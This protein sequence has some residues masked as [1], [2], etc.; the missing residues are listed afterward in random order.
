MVFI[1]HEKCSKRSLFLYSMHLLLK[2]VDIYPWIYNREVSVI[3][4]SFSLNAS[5]IFG[6]QWIF[7]LIFKWLFNI[8]LYSEW[9]HILLRSW[10]IIYTMEYLFYVLSMLTSIFW[11]T[12]KFILQHFKPS[13]CLSIDERHFALHCTR[14]RMLW[15]SK[16]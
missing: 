15:I 5:S 7:F 13:L 12:I 8:I 4:F 9:I 3:C 11:F 1:L 16:D 10:Y 14:N 2:R 6:V